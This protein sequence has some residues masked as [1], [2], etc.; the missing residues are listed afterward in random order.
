MIK[1][2]FVC[3]GNI[4]RSPMAEGIFRQL[5]ESEKLSDKIY[6]DSAG[7]SNYH[8]GALPDHR[9][10]KVATTYGFTLTHRARQVCIA[11]FDEY[12]YLV[13]MDEDNLSD[14]LLHEGCDTNKKHKLLLLRSHEEIITDLNVPDPYYGDINGFV[15]VYTML[16]NANRRFLSYLIQQHHLK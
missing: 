16:L 15:G 3:L 10:R 7:T 2:L 8:I 4:C 14:L 6:C 9:M 12:N 5:V 13:A 1:V 11:D